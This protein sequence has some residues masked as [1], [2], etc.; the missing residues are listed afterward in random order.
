[1][2]D[3]ADGGDAVVA[4]PALL[5]VAQ[6]S[7]AHP[8]VPVPNHPSNAAA[9]AINPPDSA[10]RLHPPSRSAAEGHAM[11]RAERLGRLVY[12]GCS[13]T[14]EQSVASLAIA[15]VPPCTLHAPYMHPT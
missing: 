13:L 11:R 14:V 2:E 10:Q 6:S 15:M 8:L 1:M 9:T 4:A 7:P 3:E 12:P 5:I